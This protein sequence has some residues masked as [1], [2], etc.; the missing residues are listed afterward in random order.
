MAMTAPRLDVDGTRRLVADLLRPGLLGIYDRLTVYE[1]FGVLKGQSPINVLTV[2][3]VED[4]AGI[5]EDGS[6]NVLT[7]QRIRVDGFQNWTFGVARSHRLLTRLDEALA[8][9]GNGHGWTLSGKTLGVGPLEVEPPMFVARDGTQEVPINRLLKNNFW[10][11]SHVIRL[12]DPSKA[13]LLPFLDDRRRLQSLS[14]AISAHVPMSLAGMADFLGDILIQIP[15]TAIVANVIAPK[16]GGPMEVKVAWHPS[17]L[18]RNLRAAARMRSDTALTGAA[19]S[20]SFTHA[21]PLAVASHVD[22]VEAEIW[23]EETGILLAA[24]VPTSTISQIGFSLRLAEPEPRVFT[25]RDAAD[26]PAAARVSLIRVFPPQFAGTSRETNADRWRHR[27]NNLEE[28][29]RLAET[30]DFVQYRPTAGHNGERE[31]ALNDIRFLITTHGE[32]GVDLW[33]PYLAADDLLQTLF[34]S[35]LLGAPLRAIT[36]G[37]D[38]PKCACKASPG[39]LEPATQTAYVERQRATLARDGGNLRGLQLEYRIRIGQKG[40]AFHDRFL[41][42]P[43]VPNGPAAW[44]LGTSVNSLGKAHHILQR[45]S[46]GALVAGA[47]SDLWAEL[48]EPDHLVWRSM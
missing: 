19:F 25:T 44:S 13:E 42:F 32:R 17:V 21:A 11:G 30:R 14:E 6:P 27:R 38:P 15:V 18:P 3:V 24:T 48:N 40:W 45:V 33:D 2:A 35:P 16:G 22:P 23:D 10:S 8:A 1:V 34:W 5:H 39:Q 26:T 46:N 43:N 47:F 29:R 7:A 37:R 28:S 12:C 31:R 36:G 20:E 9:F 41:I 4:L